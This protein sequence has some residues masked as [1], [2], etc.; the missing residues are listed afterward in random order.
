M[1]RSIG[2]TV[3]RCLLATLLMIL[4][5]E[6]CALAASPANEEMAIALAS[7]QANEQWAFTSE[8]GV[9]SDGEL[10]FDGRAQLVSA[11]FTPYEWEDVSLRASFRV[12]PQEQGVLACGFVVRAADDASANYY[13]HF[14]RDQAILVRADKDN[15]WNEIKRV[16]GLNKPAGKWH[17]AELTCVGE[18]LKVSLNGKL[19]FEASDGTLQR[20]RIGF[21]GSQ[22]RVHVKDIVVAG[23]P[24]QPQRK[25]VIPRPN[26]M[27]VCHDA[28]AG[29]YEAFPDVCRLQDGRLMCVIYASYHHIGLPKPELPKGGRIVACLSSDEGRTWSQPEVLFDSP[30]DDRDPSIVQ[31]KNGRLICNFFSLRRNK[32]PDQPL[33]DPYAEPWT[34][35]GTWIVTSDDAGKTWSDPT[36]LK[37]G[38]CFTSSPIRELSNGRLILGLYRE[39]DGKANGA[40]IFSDDAGKTWGEVVELDN[41]GLR[42]DA[43][44]DIVELSPG[45]LLAAQRGSGDPLHWATTEDNGTSWAKSQPAAFTAHC[46]Y[47]HRAADGVFVF[48]YRQV[49]GGGK[50]TVM[51]TAIRISR[52]GCQTWGDPLMVDDVVGAYPSMVNLKDGSILIA[53][54]EEGAGCDIRAK[55]FRVTDAGVEFL[56]LSPE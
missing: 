33:L 28:G 5:V 42:L 40:V 1:K 20:G 9:L 27:I 56:S 35:L 13:V 10:V 55:R 45:R 36:Q 51:N 22:G 50:K 54:Y 24:L 48:G 29:G 21:Y 8:T 4:A 46:P 19:L 2:V 49:T 34:P 30:D 14:D 44:T 11:F 38:P 16:G 26:Y 39:A 17:T 52:D 41:R 32:G 12:E 6:C 31:L 7:R 43:E 37:S 15:V 3:S 25:L 47:L 53:Y 23:K 18:S